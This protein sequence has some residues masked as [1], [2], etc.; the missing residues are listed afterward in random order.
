MLGVVYEVH[1]IIN[2]E[3]K[4]YGPYLTADEAQ[5]VADWVVRRQQGISGPI[6]HP[7]IIAKPTSMEGVRSYDHPRL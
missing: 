3:E 6:V 5:R 7:T 4:I 1:A 2:G